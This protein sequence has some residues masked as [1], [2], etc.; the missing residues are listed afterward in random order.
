MPYLTRDESRTTTT[1]IGIS[2]E[3]LDKDRNPSATTLPDYILCPRDIH[4]TRIWT[5][6]STDNNPIDCSIM[7]P[8]R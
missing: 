6:F 8:R 5:A 2:T 3:L 4:R 7:K 1:L